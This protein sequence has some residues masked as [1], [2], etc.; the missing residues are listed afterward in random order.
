MDKGQS[1]LRR[2]GSTDDGVLLRDCSVHG[3]HMIVWAWSNTTR[4]D[5]HRHAPPTSVLIEHL[6]RIEV[7]YTLYSMY[8]GICGPW[9]NK[10][11]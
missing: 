9:V 7:E 8:L 4:L 5:C 2:V 3:R 1:M 11:W 10:C 6:V